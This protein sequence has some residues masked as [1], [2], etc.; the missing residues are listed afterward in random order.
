MACSPSACLGPRGSLYWPE[1]SSQC[2]C[3]PTL[4]CLWILGSLPKS[5]WIL[6]SLPFCVCSHEFFWQAPRLNSW[7][8]F[9]LCTS[10]E[11][12]YLGSLFLLHGKQRWLRGATLRPALRQHHSSNTEAISRMSVE[13]LHNIILAWNT[14]YKCSKDALLYMFFYFDFICPGLQS[15]RS[16]PYLILASLFP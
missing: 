10:E 2:C 16:S 6:Q 13:A 4:G 3:K 14:Q 12:W 5:P 8:T 15:I 1:R 7:L 9:C 11:P